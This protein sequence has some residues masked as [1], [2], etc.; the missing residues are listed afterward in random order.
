M[1]FKKDNLRLGLFLGLIGPMHRAGSRLFCKF[2]VIP[3]KEFL[4]L[5][6]A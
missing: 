6:H 5:L 2:P 1:I 3:F 4:G